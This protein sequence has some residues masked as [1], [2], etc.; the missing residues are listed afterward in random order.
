MGPAIVICC[1]LLGVFA[2]GVYPLALELV[3]ECTY[4]VDQATPTALIFLSSSLQGVF[5]MEI[6]N[7]LGGPLTEEEMQIQSCVSLTDTGHQQPKDYSNYLYFITGYM[8]TFV[9]IFMIFFG[10]ELKRTKADQE[11]RQASLSSKDAEEGA[12]NIVRVEEE[13]L[14]SSECSSTDA[15]S[16]ISSSLIE[17]TSTVEA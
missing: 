9:I 7:Y 3:V 10:T 17:S 12:R 4:P 16:K 11:I 8:M 1:A 15:G 14:M 6:E 5:L 13:K 2:L